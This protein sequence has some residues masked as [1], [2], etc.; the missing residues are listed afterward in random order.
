MKINKSFQ[1]IQ[2][3]GNGGEFVALDVVGKRAKIEMEE[4]QR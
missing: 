1:N 4:G 3:S 2:G